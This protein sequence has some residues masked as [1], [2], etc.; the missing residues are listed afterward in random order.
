[1]KIEDEYSQDRSPLDPLD[2]GMNEP[3]ALDGTTGDLLPGTEAAINELADHLADEPDGWH[4]NVELLNALAI[5]PVE[6]QVFTRASILWMTLVVEG[7]MAAIGIGLAWWLDIPLWETFRWE[8]REI[9]LGFAAAL[10]MIGFLFLAARSQ[11]DSLVRI[12]RLLKEGLLPRLKACRQV[13]LIALAIM[14]GCGEELL[15]RTFGQQYLENLI[16]PISGLLIASVVFG[17]LHCI[18]TMYALLTFLAGVYLGLIWWV[19]DRN[20]VSV[21]IAH[22]VYDWVAFA[23][24]LRLN[25]PDKNVEAERN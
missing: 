18:S 6:L 22:A 5:E 20:S 24:L 15:F 17:L 4:G 21:M 9:G 23:Y 25:R 3:H 12:R 16:D 14:A 11:L 2:G 10:P 13:D 7:G 8:P 1:M 19:T